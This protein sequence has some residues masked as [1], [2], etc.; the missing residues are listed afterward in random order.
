MNPIEIA[1]FILGLINVALVVRRSLWNY[2]FGILMVLLYGRIFFDAKLYS[3][4]LLQIFFLAAQLYGWWH[5]S[6]TSA[7]LGEVQVERMPRPHQAL[8]AA[9]NVAAVLLWGTMMHLYTDAASPWW[10]AA[11]AMLSVSAQIL[12][13]RR[14][15]ES[16]A[17]WIVVDLLSIGLFA[18]RGLWLTAL[19]YTI[20]L[21]LAGWGLI[22]WRRAARG[23]STPAPQAP[24]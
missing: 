22:A 8:W 16:W 18:S 21:V 14:Y 24:A 12:Q 7:R 1:A 23:L 20:F 5:W 3:D 4:S 6:R 13:S 9:G 19:L 11:V 10:D 15:L 2:P 17:I